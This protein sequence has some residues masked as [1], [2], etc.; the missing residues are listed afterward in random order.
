M[1]SGP[2]M[3]LKRTLL[4]IK[5]PEIM[6]VGLNTLSKLAENHELKEKILGDECLENIIKKMDEYMGN[7]KSCEA[8]LNFLI[9]NVNHEKVVNAIFE[10]KGL[11]SILCMMELHLN[12]KSIEEKV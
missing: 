11:E 9:G 4:E 6:E 3:I 7:E 8:L 5:S 12:N 10:K 2:L 1:D